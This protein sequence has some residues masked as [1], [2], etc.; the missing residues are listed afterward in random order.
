MCSTNT[1]PPITVL[2]AKPALY[3]F[4]KYILIKDSTNSISWCAPSDAVLYRLYLILYYIAFRL[5][6]L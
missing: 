2:L 5:N 4:F 1:T 3:V 6:A